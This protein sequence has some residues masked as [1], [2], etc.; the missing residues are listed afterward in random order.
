M[1]LCISS[2][3]HSELLALAAASPETEVCGLLVGRDDVDRIVPAAN[4]S[5]D[6][7]RTFEIDPI[8]LFA[9]IRSERENGDKLFGYYHS[10]PTGRAFPSKADAE[11]AT[12]D[13]R[14]WVIIAEGQITAWRLNARGAFEA[15]ELII[16]V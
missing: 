9:A 1:A 4:L 15:V 11:Q 13:G 10:H 5:S 2:K 6:R 16:A 3:L 14:V 8:V 7:R 12:A